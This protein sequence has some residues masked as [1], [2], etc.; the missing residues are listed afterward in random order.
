MTLD[1][2][3]WMFPVAF[4]LFESESE[5]NWEWFL[6]QLCRAI[7]P[8]TPLAICIDACKGLTN[9]VLT[10]FPQAERRE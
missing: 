4:G 7:G 8:V 6:R 5:A 2:H 3:N 10:V 9:A 1:G